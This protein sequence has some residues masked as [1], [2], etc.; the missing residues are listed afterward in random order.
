MINE[1]ILED[2]RAR[3]E[4]TLFI[5]SLDGLEEMELKEEEEKC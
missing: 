1:E 2:M 4:M 5:A 3:K